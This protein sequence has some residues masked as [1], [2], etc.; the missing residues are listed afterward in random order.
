MPVLLR[1]LLAVESLALRSCTGGAGL[2]RLVSWVAPTEL[3]DPTPW[4]DGGELIL[5]TGLRLRTAAAQAAFVSRLAEAGA[6]GIGFG[7]GLSHTAV[8]RALL[9]AAQGVGLPVLDVPYDT[10]FIAVGR[11]VAERIAA[12]RHTA[13]RRLVDAHDRLTQA[14]LAGEGLDQ[15][16]RTLRRQIGGPAA[17]LAADGGM[18]AGALPPTQAHRLEVEVDGVAVAWLVAGVSERPEPLP[19]AARLV[20]L[21]LARRLSFLA[22]R[23][24]QLGRLLEEVLTGPPDRS[25]GSSPGW[26]PG[27]STGSSP[28][29]ADQGED[30]LLAVHGVDPGRR[31]QVLLGHWTASRPGREEETRRRLGRL[32]WSPAQLGDRADDSSAGPAHPPLSAVVEGV[33]MVL[34]PED[35]GNPEDFAEAQAKG[36]WEAL[37]RDPLRGTSAAV[38]LSAPGSG[39]RGL[40]EG[41]LEA[42]AALSRGA[43]APV[44]APLRLADLLLS[45]PSPAV[46][47]LSEQM[48]L[49][50][51]R[52]DA[53][54]RAD[55]VGTL[56]RY[57]ATDG[58]VQATAEQL[59]V[60][61]NTVRYRLTQ[62]EEL[63]GR[64]L[65]STSD[66]AELWLALLAI[67][68]TPI[69]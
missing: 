25:A 22:G 64:S 27:W 61:R 14:V 21:E 11:H 69:E 37:R 28:G 23:R 54:H 42:R 3:A 13:Q 31:Y 38:G 53:E 66:R 10:P 24:V 68:R 58:S 45:R 16:L 29:S 32:S 52:F 18:L 41:Y 63:T 33:L 2:D 19:Y 4:M 50:L 9:A 39:A 7:T 65:S 60:H 43:A 12:E 1:D 67:G 26:A 47:Q 6:A 62:I 49:P 55:L 8:P 5:T 35:R 17:V 34:L 51:S 46:R 44:A 56:R 48:L 36:L 30:R 20:G 40:Q 15:L 59:F 57:L